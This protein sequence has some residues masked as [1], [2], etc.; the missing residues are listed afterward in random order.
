MKIVVL[1]G[2]TLN[3][4]DLAWDELK[5]LGSLTVYEKTL[6]EDTL[7]RIG[8]AEAVFTNKTL[9][10]K[11]IM[12][13][14][15]NLAFIGVLAT[16]Y[17]VVD[18]QAARERSIPV[19][20][21]PAYSTSS[22]AQ[23][24]FALLLEVCHHVAHHNKAVQEGRWT[25]SPHF[26]FWDTPLIELADKTMGIIGYGRIGQATAYIARA[27]GMKVLAYS[28]SRKGPVDAT[29]D[30]VLKNSD[31][32][33]LHCPLTEKTKHIIRQETIAKMKDGVILINTARG[34]LINEAD[35]RNALTSGKLYAAA[36]DV[37]S[38]EPIGADS[39]LL[40]LDNCM[41]TP[42]IAWAPK[43]ARQRLMDIAVANLQS[44]L[45]GKPQNVVN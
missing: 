20:N 16:G 22:V 34:P 14:A 19:C 44:F 12:E 35:L 21:V 37:A 40:G 36:M 43:E 29:L 39:P 9:L 41:I 33:S 6:P 32:I 38:E 15:P 4:G 2:Y 24:V 42:H 3:P 26:C 31:V 13:K 17:N 7:S 18:L 8:N 11:D 28:P 5:K 10:T 25:N 45:D 23:F 27:F 30:E 1:D